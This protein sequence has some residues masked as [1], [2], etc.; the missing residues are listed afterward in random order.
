MSAAVCHLLF[1]VNIIDIKLPAL[2][3]FTT[4]ATKT[5]N[6]R[7]CWE[8]RSGPGALCFLSASQ[9][10]EVGS[11]TR[12]PARPLTRWSS[13]PSSCPTLSPQEGLLRTCSSGGTVPPPPPSPPHSRCS[14]F[15]CRLLF[16]LVLN[17]GHCRSAASHSWKT[18]AKKMS[19]DQSFLCSCVSVITLEVL[20]LPPPPLLAVFPRQLRILPGQRL[21]DW[22]V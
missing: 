22:Q 3:S 6:V 20:L 16:I 5:P 18:L 4:S 8:G 10:Q 12:S 21:P 19:S 17:T 11:V 14:I 15:I 2:A 1:Y 13:P 9:C 7:S